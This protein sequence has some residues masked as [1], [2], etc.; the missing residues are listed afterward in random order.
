MRL[1]TRKEAP[2]VGVI[3]ELTAAIDSACALR[4]DGR[5]FCWGETEHSWGPVLPIGTDTM[6][7]R[8]DAGRLIDMFTWYNSVRLLA[9]GSIHSPGSAAP[10]RL[11]AGPYQAVAAVREIGCALDLDGH[12]KCWIWGRER[13]P[14]TDVEYKRID[15]GGGTVCGIKADDSALHCWAAYDRVRLGTEPEGAFRSVDIGYHHTICALR[16]EGTVECWWPYGQNSRSGLDTRAAPEQAESR[17]V[18]A[19]RW[20]GQR[21]A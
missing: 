17:M 4:P 19:T 15:G 13:S 2:T 3:I 20:V 9:D 8:S 11:K 1:L 12:I 14:S 5:V 16:L 18:R 10:P 6:T 21:V 7:D